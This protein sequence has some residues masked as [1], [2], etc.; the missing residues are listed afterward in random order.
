MNKIK[1]SSCGKIIS[2]NQKECPECGL[3]RVDSVP[4]ASSGGYKDA[5]FYGQCGLCG[6]RGR[7]I[8][9]ISSAHQTNYRCYECWNSLAEIEKRGY[10][11]SAKT[12][13]FGTAE[14]SKYWTE[15]QAE[16]Q[17]ALIQYYNKPLFYN[18]KPDMESLGKVAKNITDAARF[19]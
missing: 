3:R 6:A 16:Y 8:A 2:A 9:E 11:V 18:E 5:P 10:F 7:K 14:Q 19:K 13:A 1:C 15:E 4:L 12:K 17:Q